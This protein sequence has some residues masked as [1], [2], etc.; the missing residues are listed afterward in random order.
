MLT[1]LPNVTKHMHRLQE[2]EKL[3]EAEDTNAVMLIEEQGELI[4]RMVNHD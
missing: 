1:S 2:I 3:L 4:D